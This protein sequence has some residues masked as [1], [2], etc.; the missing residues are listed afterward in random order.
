MIDFGHNIV[1]ARLATND[2]KGI[3]ATDEASII[4]DRG[5]NDERSVTELDSD[6]ADENPFLAILN[7]SVMVQPIPE[8]KPEIVSSEQATESILDE[9]SV[10][11]RKT[12]AT[13]VIEQAVSPE[14][15]LQV[16][17]TDPA[18]IEGYNVAL[19]W[20]DSEIFQPILSSSFES[21][22]AQGRIEV[23]LKQELEQVSLGMQT[24]TESEA[25]G[26]AIEH[27]AMPEFTQQGYSQEYETE[28]TLEELQ[29]TVGIQP[30]KNKLNEALDVFQG[31]SSEHKL[32]GLTAITTATNIQS[33]MIVEQRSAEKVN[34]NGLVSMEIPVSV[35]EPHWVDEFSERVLWLGQNNEIKSAHIKINPESLGPIEISIKMLKDEASVTITT[36]SSDIKSL[37][38][39][40]THELREMMGSRGIN[41][42]E[43][44]IESDGQSRSFHQ[45]HNEASYEEFTTAEEVIEATPLD[46]RKPK[47]LVDYFA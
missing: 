4:F 25:K 5:V 47:G 38:H 36:H 43:L 22:M 28:D 10:S 23:D 41:L 34:A 8:T 7:Q 45:D 16:N 14:T 37:V 13:Q 12:V 27:E 18:F 9:S 33:T 44:S 39:Q 31:R 6:K 17:E 15:Q 46:S 26:I 30:K 1:N 3:E 42:A 20:I 2:T 24:S 11:E 32:S 21:L 35:T 29:N 19:T 40:A